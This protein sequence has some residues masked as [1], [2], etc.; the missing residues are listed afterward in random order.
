MYARRTESGRCLT[1]AK[2]RLEN[3]VGLI[4]STVA[5]RMRTTL[6]PNTQYVKTIYQINHPVGSRFHGM[7]VSIGSQYESGLQHYPQAI[8]ARIDTP[9]CL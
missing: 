6:T 2:S 1:I 8:F 7:L 5:Q 4:S 3:A 9:R